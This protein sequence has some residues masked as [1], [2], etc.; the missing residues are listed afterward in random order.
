MLPGQ[1]AQEKMLTVPEGPELQINKNIIMLKAI[2]F[3]CYFTF[4]AYSTIAQAKPEP[5]Q[6]PEELSLVLRNYEKHWRAKDA[7]KLA[8]LFAVEGYVLSS[9]NPPVQG[10]K[11]IQQLYEKAGGPLHL[12]AFDY[13]IENDLAYIIGGYSSAE[14]K[15]PSGKYTL[16][17]I[18]ENGNWLIQSDMD[19]GNTRKPY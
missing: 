12:F 9:G 4:L 2:L 8:S 10:R 13:K 7:E 1:E 19:N 14:N 18:R 3:S 15:K 5:I 16:I 6:L 17:L 11:E